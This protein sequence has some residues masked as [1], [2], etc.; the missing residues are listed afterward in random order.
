MFIVDPWRQDVTVNIRKQQ[1]GF[2]TDQSPDRETFPKKNKL[3]SVSV[4]STTSVPQQKKSGNCG[5]HM[6]RL[7]K[8]ILADRKDFDW[9]EDDMEIIG[10]KMAVEIFS[11]SRPV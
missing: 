7:I 4:V 6:L 11:I 10:E 1:A 8:Y 9:S 3:F 5:P 2:Y